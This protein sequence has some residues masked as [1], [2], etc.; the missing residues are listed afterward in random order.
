MWMD[1]SVRFQTK[2][3]S[4]AFTHAQSL[5]VSASI[6]FGPIAARTQK[7][8]FQFLEESP[9][10]YRDTNELEA[11][12]IMIY[13]TDFIIQYFMVPWVSCA[14]CKGCMVPKISP[15]KYLNC[16]IENYYFSCHRFDQS[17]LSILMT[18]IF[19][20]DL[21]AHIMLHTFYKIC[22]GGTDQPY[23]PDFMNKI[24]TRY[25]RTCF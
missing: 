22:K 1:A 6:G 3:L 12:F 13:A 10:L 24:V 23:L 14:L 2:H 8:T 4:W 19:N 16:K 21:Q 15:E 20:Q 17:I 9:C 11:T 5:G 18:R 25:L 7:A